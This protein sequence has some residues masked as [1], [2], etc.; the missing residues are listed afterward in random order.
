MKSSWIPNMI[1]FAFTDRVDGESVFYW[2]WRNGIY[3]SP[4]TSR[5]GFIL[6]FKVKAS[7]ETSALVAICKKLGTGNETNHTA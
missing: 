2:S 6:S 1:M 4:A 5:L 7:K 3:M